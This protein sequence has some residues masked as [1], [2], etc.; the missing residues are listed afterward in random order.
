MRRL[1]WGIVIA[2]VLVAVVMGCSG[3]HRYDARL[4]AADSLMQPAPDSAL[5]LIEALPIDS[6]TDEG[7]RAY[8]DLLLTQARYRCYIVATSDSGINRALAYYRAHSGEREKL[9]RAYIYKGA[10]MD[11]L[12][13]P[14]SAMFYYKHAEATADEK[15]Y[16]NLGQINTR[17]ADLYRRYY[18]DKEICFEKYCNA[19]K[20]YK[21]LGDK[22]KQQNCY[23]NM[24]GCVG[25][26]GRGNA[27]DYLEQALE[28][29][30]ELNDSLSI[31]KCYELWS[32]Q[33]SME[34]STRS[35]A[36]RIALKCLNNYPK[37]MNLD[38]IIDLAFIYVMDDM[39]DSARYYLNI[40]ERYPANDHMGQIQTRKNS[41]LA[42]IAKRQKYPTQN[43]YY[44]CESQ[45]V[46]DSMVNNQHR[47]MIQHIENAN[48]AQ[49][50]RTKNRHIDFMRWLLISFAFVFVITA[51]M[52]ALSILAFRRH[53]KAKTKEHEKMKD[54]LNAVICDL[55]EKLK[56][57][58][59]GNTK[60][61]AIV[62][63]RMEA[64]QEL[65]DSIK[66]KSK[67]E[68]SGKNRKILTL[69]NILG[70]LDDQYDLLKVDLSDSFW[71]KI[72]HSVD[73]E[74][75]GIVTFV[76]S[77]YPNLSTRDIRIFCLLCTRIT[78]QIMK[79]CM[80]LTSPRSASN[81]RSLIMKKLN[82]NMTFEE[83]LSNY[84]KGKINR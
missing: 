57:S 56:C 30:V 21:F 22:P 27:E 63:T 35:E 7:D 49:Q 17:I 48:I 80:N 33:L 82:L 37:F 52:M 64:F 66:F 72:R 58:K 32:R 8:R 84:M 69:R 14:D 4:V 36:K 43:D 70:S 1:L 71:E 51:I 40:A 25:I 53:L 45:R 50:A 83:F 15:D 20:Y 39:I 73:G 67:N 29:A 23:F 77:N 3:A 13:H 47:Y 54:E 60:A 44:S 2:A 34:D 59:D 26:T 62:K 10:V 18:G 41:I 46:A 42:I 68:D 12:G 28:L 81:Y 79:L 65:F 76:E 75:N 24:A 55:N 6:L 9:T 16:V 5:A 38:L 31:V 61:T 11:E 74:F 19:L 78:P